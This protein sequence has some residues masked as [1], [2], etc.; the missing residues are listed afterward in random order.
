ME[1]ENHENGLET[2]ASHV[3]AMIFFW[4]YLKQ[5]VMQDG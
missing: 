4:K 2:L 1:S 5:V 3:E